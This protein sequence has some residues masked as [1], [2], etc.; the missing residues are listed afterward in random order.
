[1]PARAGFTG[2][3]GTVS[4]IL[5]MLE[6]DFSYAFIDTPD[7]WDFTAEEISVRGWVV[8]KEDEELS[9]IRASLDG[10]ITYG[11]MGWDR[12]DVQE[13]FDGRM[14]ARRS[15]FLI[16]IKPW[17]RAFPVPNPALD[18]KPKHW[19][20]VCSTSIDTFIGPNQLRFGPKRPGCS[21]N[22][23]LRSP[24]CCRKMT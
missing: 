17:E 18:S 12:P 5:F 7:S 22:S 10:V 23:R 3:T 4:F 11:I 20:R 19:R 16:V 15:G 6:N 13:R 8:A 24:P 1:M 14:T 2:P 21:P 9:D